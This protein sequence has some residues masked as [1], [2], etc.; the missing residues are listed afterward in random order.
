MRAMFSDKARMSLHA[1]QRVFEKNAA[2]H[3]FK[4]ASAFL[5][6]FCLLA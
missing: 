1:D 5:G 4:E 2:F 3:F 6:S